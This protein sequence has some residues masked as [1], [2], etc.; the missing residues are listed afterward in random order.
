MHKDMTSSP[1]NKAPKACAFRVFRRFKPHL[2]MILVQ[3]SYT[4]LYFITEA[5]FN[6]GLNPHVYVTYRHIVGGLVMFPIAY[7]TERKVRPKMTLFVFLEISLLSFLGVG[8]TVNMYFASMRYTS[9]TFITA[10]I[11]TTSC[12]TFIFAVILRLEHVD[13]RDPRGIAKILGSLMSLAG[14][15]AMTLY[16]GPALHSLKDV[17]IHIGNNSVHKNWMKGSILIVAS[18]ISASIWYIL[19]ASTLKKYPAELSLTAWLNCIGGALSAVFTILIE[20]RSAAPWSITSNIDFWSIVYSGVIC[21]GL[22]IAIQLW[23]TK[24]KGPVFVTSFN[25]LTAVMVATLA[26]LVVGEKLHMG[27][28]AGGIMVIVGLYTLLWGKERDQGFSKPQEQSFPNCD[29]QEPKSK[30]VTT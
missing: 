2:L 3:M 6:S 25:P 18:C 4:A 10:M 14:V 7:F 23:C 21:C 26:Y 27:S 8:L 13:V 22:T 28:I 15:T 5:A 30:N 17:A 20:H 11:N 24:Q 9:P 1:E 12:L 19:Q 16:K 29:D